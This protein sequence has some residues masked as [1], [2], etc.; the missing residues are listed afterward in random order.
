MDKKGTIDRFHE[1][2]DSL[3]TAVGEQLDAAKR[4]YSDALDKSGNP[5]DGDAA[6]QANAEAMQALAAEL[7]SLDPKTI[8]LINAMGILTTTPGVM[9]SI[10]WMEIVRAM[11]NLISQEAKKQQVNASMDGDVAA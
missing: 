11:R 7:K 1:Q 5:D 4:T 2:R 6:K 3:K 9:K 8:A 10:L